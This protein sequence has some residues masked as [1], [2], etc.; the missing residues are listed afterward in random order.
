[1]GERRKHTSRTH[2][3]FSTHIPRPARSPQCS[4]QPTWTSHPSPLHPAAQKHRPT[5]HVP[6]P[7]QLT[8]CASAF[9][10]ASSLLLL[11]RPRTNATRRWGVFFFDADRTSRL[12]LETEPG[13]GTASEHVAPVKPGLHQQRPAF[14]GGEGER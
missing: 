3:S 4:G 8:C 1:M 2:H 13:H 14:G 6:C 11:F 5:A 12:E 9:V 7:L 10:A